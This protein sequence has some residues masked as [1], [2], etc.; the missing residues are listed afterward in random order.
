M[1]LRIKI[2]GFLL[3]VVKITIKF[4]LI[5][6]VKTVKKKFIQIITYKLRNLKS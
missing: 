2:N 6:H 1:N 5:S 4:I 3:V